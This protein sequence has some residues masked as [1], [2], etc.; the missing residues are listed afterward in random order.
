MK[1]EAMVMKD[2]LFMELDNINLKPLP[3]DHI[4]IKVYRSG[5]CGTDIE[6]FRG[7]LPY[8][9]TSRISYP[10]VAGH[11]WSG[12]VVEIGP[13]VKD[14]NI[15]DRV[16]GELHMGCGVC[17]NCK[18]GQYN[19]CLNIKRIGIGDIPG[20]FARYMQLPRNLV[21]KLPKEIDY[22]KGA[23]IE[24]TAVALKGVN[25]INFDGGEKV[26]V[27]GTGAIG[28]MAVNICRVY[29]AGE[30]VLVGS[31]KRLL[32]K[33]VGHKLGADQFMTFDQVTQEMFNSFDIAIEASG[34]NKVISTMF[35]LVKPGGQ[36]S[37][38]G[39]ADKAVS[40]LDISRI[41][42]KSFSIFGSLGS[43]GVWKNVIS[44][45]QRGYLKPELL[46]TH[47]FEFK[48]LGKVLKNINGLK[49]EGLIKASI[50]IGG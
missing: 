16:S 39:I 2:K 34:S 24:P 14:I 50:K 47:E 46:V 4:R 20:S 48:N 26:I 23:L 36:I 45:M 33:E 22:K 13:D 32:K 19:A 9:K 6:L 40:N 15:G 17:S 44:L 30:I 31:K 41:A 10:I 8:L 3:S 1:V 5:I 25:F 27:F 38:V 28:L 37:L 42:T 12:K 35:D 7:T 49:D 21:Y 11:E 18:N 43:A 29:G